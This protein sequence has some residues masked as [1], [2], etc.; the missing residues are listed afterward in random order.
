ML[1]IVVIN[2]E[3]ITVNIYNLYYTFYIALCPSSMFYYTGDSS[4]DCSSIECILKVVH[5]ASYSNLCS[6]IIWN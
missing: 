1:T 5:F 6:R 3:S 2:I 4:T